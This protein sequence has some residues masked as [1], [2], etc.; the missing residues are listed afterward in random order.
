MTG[1]DDMFR[2]LDERRIGK[3]VTA[4]VIRSSG[5]IDIEVRPDECEREH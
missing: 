4:T 1:V 2:L 3:A 5:L